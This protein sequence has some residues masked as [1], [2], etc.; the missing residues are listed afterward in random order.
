MFGLRGLKILRREGEPRKGEAFSGGA[1]EGD[2][3]EVRRPKRADG[4]DPN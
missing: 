4:P 1:T 3:R 2:V